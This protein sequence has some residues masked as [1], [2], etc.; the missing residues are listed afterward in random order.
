M[1]FQGTERQNGGIQKKR[2]GMSKRTS[3]LNL[4]IL[5]FYL[6]F[7]LDGNPSLIKKDSGRAGMTDLM[8]RCLLR[9]LVSL[10][11]VL[12]IIGF[13]ILLSTCASV[14]TQHEWERVNAFAM[15]RTGIETHWQ[16]TEEDAK[17]TKEEVNKLLLDGLS[18]DDA[19]S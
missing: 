15:E 4:E 7:P 17:I 10:K 1:F 18:V 2:V 11:P 14:Q 6:S 8:H 3:F 19:V 16:Q 5:L 12:L 13:V 9:R